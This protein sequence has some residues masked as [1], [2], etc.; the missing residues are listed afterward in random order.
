MSG[1]INT[2]LSGIKSFWRK[3]TPVLHPVPPVASLMDLSITAL[4]KR[5]E[6]IGQPGQPAPSLRE[7]ESVTWFI[8][9]TSPVA[10]KIKE[11]ENGILQTKP[12]GVTPESFLQ[13]NVITMFKALKEA[14]PVPLTDLA[15]IS[16]WEDDALQK[17]YAYLVEKNP[18]QFPRL[19]NVNEIKRFLD[20]PKNLPAIQ[21]V[22][23]ISVEG[24]KVV[25]S[26]L[27]KF[28][29]L[30]SLILKKGEISFIPEW[31]G[32]LKNLTCLD[33]NKNRIQKIPDSLGNL[34]NLQLLSLDHNQIDAI[35]DCLGRLTELVMLC[36]SDN[37]IRTIPTTLSKLT[38]LFQL[39]L[40]NNQI[41]EFPAWIS[42]L[43]RFSSKSYGAWLR[44]SHNKI[45]EI[46]TTIPMSP[47]ARIFLDYNEIITR[48]DGGATENIDLY[49]NPVIEYVSI[50][51]KSFPVVIYPDEE[52][53]QD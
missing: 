49:K 35:P 40:S 23:Y 10:Q 51:G 50:F 48:C 7:W 18:E 14:Y 46:P 6:I 38:K 29:N 25:P 41:K 43:P 5:Y 22:E 19:N 3:P 47:H 24:I 36:L 20:D 28:S 16:A 11:I 34:T 27:L 53:P 17:I 8:N 33:F 31:I 42:S 32:N 44:L 15:K 1:I 12:E 30:S 39:Y 9:E 26:Q 4:A 21:S 13:A 2:I 52:E 45:R 37:Q